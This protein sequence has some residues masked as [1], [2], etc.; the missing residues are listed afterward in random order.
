M[1]VVYWG[2]ASGPIPP[3]NISRLAAK[4]VS[5]MRATVMQ[6]IVTKEEFQY[7]A[8][9]AIDLIQS[10]KLNIKIHKVYDLE[11]VKQAHEDL[12]GRKTTGKLLLKV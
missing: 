7:Y 11:D 9:S 5:I 2:N 12:E 8:N 4:N 10:G 6:Y 3:I 1:I